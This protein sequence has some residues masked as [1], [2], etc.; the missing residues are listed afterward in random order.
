MI[1]L[2]AACARNRCIG[3]NG[4]IPWHIPGEQ[5]RF[6]TLTMGAA[7]VLGRRSFEEIGRALPG[8]RTIVL[9]SSGDFRPLGCLNARSLTEA[10]SL[11]GELD[12]FISGGAAVY[13]EALPLAEKIYLT[14]IDEDFEGD[15]FFPE[16]NGEEFIRSFDEWVDGPV[17][18]CYVTYTRTA[19]SAAE[20]VPGPRP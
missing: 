15:V 5:R 14:E 20:P 2:I 18:Y 12:V 13:A 4:R 11:A 9:S 10:I 19:R 7:V 17:P 8:R 1:A 3:R 16:F 6:R